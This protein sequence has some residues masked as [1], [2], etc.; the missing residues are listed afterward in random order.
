VFTTQAHENHLFF[1]LPLLAL[2]LP[3]R[4]S[5]GVVLG[6][7]SLTLLLNMALHD[8]LVLEALGIDIQG[9]T[10]NALRS[11][12]AAVN[13]LCWVG[14]SLARISQ[15]YVAGQELRPHPAGRRPQLQHTP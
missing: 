13:V 9:Q 14:W 3:E 12:N 10:A 8:Q 11:A 6:V 7:L 15:H 2:A 4:R 1:A 5:L